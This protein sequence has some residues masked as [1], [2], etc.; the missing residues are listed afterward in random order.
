[1]FLSFLFIDLQK[2]GSSKGVD[3]LKSIK[4]NLVMLVVVFSLITSL[5]TSV[6]AAESGSITIHAFDPENT[7][8]PIPG[9]NVT[10]YYVA[11][12]SDTGSTHYVVDPLFMGYTGKLY[13]KTSEEY[14][15][16]AKA[17][18]AYTK[19]AGI[20]GITQTTS[21]AGYANFG[22]LKKGLYL[23]AQT[24]SLPQGYKEFV[25]FLVELPLYDGSKYV[26]DIQVYPKLEKLPP[27]VIPTPPV[28]EAN[29]T[30]TP[31]PIDE[32]D[33]P[34][35][36]IPQTGMMMWPVP[37][38][39]ILGGGFLLSGGISVVVTKRKEKSNRIK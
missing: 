19:T 24:G 35:A 14:V 2:S 6:S 1:M 15:A 9:E 36:P 5:C 27:V 30:P 33:T 8:V 31:V 28:P 23:V 7:A 21:S 34:E 11:Q 10:L 32:P 13:W 39:A 12:L 4:M 17:L 20:Q 18:Q 25:P 29:V 37:V 16:V 22:N 26:Y 3:T 38:M